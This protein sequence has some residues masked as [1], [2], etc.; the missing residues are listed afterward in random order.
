MVLQEYSFSD[1]LKTVIVFSWISYRLMLTC[2]TYEEDGWI[3]IR[4]IPKILKALKEGVRF[5][6]FTPEITIP[7]A[8]LDGRTITYHTRFYK[9]KDEIHCIVTNDERRRLL[10]LLERFLNQE[11]NN[12][13]TLKQLRS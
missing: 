4:T 12:P 11:S 1:K 2:Y 5:V 8:T 9:V 13:I 3:S 7:L 6:L 10:R